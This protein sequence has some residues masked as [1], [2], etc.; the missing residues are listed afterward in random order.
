M[1][2]LD[3]FESYSLGNIAGQGSWLTCLGQMDI[4]AGK[5]IQSNSASGEVCARLNA[6]AISANHYSQIYIYSRGASR[7]IGPAVRCSGVTPNA[8]WYELYADNSG[9]YLTVVVNDAYA[10]IAQKAGSGAV[11]DGDI[12]KLDVN[13][14]TL[15]CYINGAVATAMGDA[16]SPAT[17]TAGVYTDSRLSTGTPGISGYGNSTT[18]Y[19]DSFECTDIF[20]YKGVMYEWNGSVW[21]P[22]PLMKRETST[23]PTK[24][25]SYWDGSQWQLVQAH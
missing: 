5:Y 8:C 19:G 14:T 21:A 11:S 9:L 20:T 15:T 16:T 17:G 4:I 18:T 25:M 2:Y 22:R 12:L 7:A 6:P 24:P 1:A 23:W 10:L 3:T 13:G